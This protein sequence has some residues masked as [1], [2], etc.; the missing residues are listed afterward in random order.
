[1]A[2]LAIGIPLY[3]AGERYPHLSAEEAASPNYNLVG[4]HILY[5]DG[6]YV[7]NLMLARSGMLPFFVAACVLI[8]LWARREFGDLAAFLS[9]LMFSTTP[10]VLALSSL[11]YTDLVAATTQF[12]AVFAFTI[13]LDKPS[14]RSALLL[15][16]AIGLAL[17][18]KL[19]TLLFLP[20]AAAAI[21]GC[22]WFFARDSS[23]NVLKI[24]WKGLIA[25]VAI[26]IVVLWGGYGFSVGH[27]RQEMGLTPESMPSFQHFPSPLRAVTRAIVLKDPIVPAP[28]LLHG[29]ATA[30]VLNKT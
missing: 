8:F 2:R 9:V 27:V 28:A 4:N 10:I 18:S 13:W 22:K 20:A 7:R 26:A 11:A 19:T 25:A 23:T 17:M 30:W 5:D 21:V 1:L 16:A 3:F 24:H 14:R 6:H 12:A 15:G 29:F